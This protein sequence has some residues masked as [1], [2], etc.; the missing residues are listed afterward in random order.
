MVLEQ[1]LDVF[2]G[3]ASTIL[4]IAACLTLFVN[5]IRKKFIKWARNIGKD[6]ARKEG[7]RV[8]EQLNT[9]INIVVKDIED[10]IELD[11]KQTEALISLLRSSITHIYYKNE[12]EQTLREYE[13]KS[14][15]SHFEAYKSLGGNSFVHQLV[16]RMSKWK[17]I[18]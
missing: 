2:G 16:E 13:A 9:N 17:I 14:L 15:A 8:L 6:E 4:S 12:K 7:D 18:D 1:F 11:K 5:P 3:L 10:Q